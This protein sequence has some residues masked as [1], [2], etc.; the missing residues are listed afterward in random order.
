MDFQSLPKD[1]Y[2]YNAAFVVIDRL[3][4]QSIS[5]LYFKTTTAKEIACLYIQHIYCI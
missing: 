4:K 2:S 5:I 3:S 1:S